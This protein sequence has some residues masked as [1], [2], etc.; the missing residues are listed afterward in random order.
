MDEL[1]QVVKADPSAVEFSDGVESESEKNALMSAMSEAFNIIHSPG[2]LVEVR[3]IYRTGEP[4]WIGTFHDAKQLFDWVAAADNEPGMARIQWSLNAPRPHWE[5]RNMLEQGKSALHKTDI[6]RRDWVVLDIDRAP[7]LPPAGEPEIHELCYNLL[8]EFEIPDPLVIS[9]GRGL[10]L[11]WRAGWSIE[12]EPDFHALCRGLAACFNV[13]GISID[14]ASSPERGFKIPGTMARKTDDP[15]TWKPVYILNPD[16]ATPVVPQSA[17]QAVI[18]ALRADGHIEEESTAQTSGDGSR[19]APVSQD[20]DIYDF[21]EFFKI[22]ILGER[23]DRFDVA[24]PL[25]GERHSGSASVT[26]FWYAENRL[27]FHCLHPD[28][29]DVTIGKLV[30]ALQEE[31]GTYPNPLF[32]ERESNIDVE[33][34]LADAETMTVQPTAAEPSVGMPTVATEGVVE[35]PVKVETVRVAI[36]AVPETPAVQPEEKPTLAEYMPPEYAGFLQAACHKPDGTPHRIGKQALES[37]KPLG[38]MLPA[39][40]AAHVYAPLVIK[41]EY[42]T[43]SSHPATYTVLL[44]GS[45]SGK[46]VSMKHAL[47]LTGEKRISPKPSPVSDNA[48]LFMIAGTVKEPKPKVPIVAP[49]K[50]LATMLEKALIEGSSLL[51]TQCELWDDGNHGG[52]KVKDL[53]IPPIDGQWQP[54]SFIG[55]LACGSPSDFA[56]KFPPGSEDGFWGRCLF[57]VQ[58]RVFHYDGEPQTRERLKIPQTVIV[59]N[60]FVLEAAAFERTLADH[61]AAY[62]FAQIWIRTAAIWEAADSVGTAI[63]GEGAISDINIPPSIFDTLDVTADAKTDDWRVATEVVEPQV[64]VTL[65][66]DIFEA[67]KNLLLAQYEIRKV[68]RPGEG[69]IEDALIVSAIVDAITKCMK[70]SGGMPVKVREVVRA[71]HLD[72]KWGYSRVMFQITG[73]DTAGTIRFTDPRAKEGSDTH[74]LG[75]IFGKRMVWLPELLSEKA[76]KMAVE[77]IGEKRKKKSNV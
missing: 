49:Y 17:W 14:D 59:P 10:N 31:H 21:C 61:K 20:F 7:G 2:K 63:H 8:V 66:R 56:V 15:A 54:Y 12:G 23:G 62:S 5:S 64:E 74:E 38:W 55:G 34:F 72:R 22:E 18:D 67:A 44:G 45:R 33:D 1:I 53:H 65:S 40:T 60:S 26:S 3:A 69:R 39:L 42:G 29:E 75:E 32:A 24:C 70:K 43:V 51:S 46:G 41:D 77:G 9:T 48:I 57:G 16:V 71:G 13:E 11:Y 25:K 30:S 37:G 28:H 4:P 47:A 73:A 50:E 19:G 68:F 27:S 36:E 6:A 52:K 35:P 58:E 76:R